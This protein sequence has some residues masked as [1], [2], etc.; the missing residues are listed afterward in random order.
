MTVRIK[1]SLVVS[2]VVAIAAPALPSIASAACTWEWLCNGGGACRQTP[3]CDA[4]DEVPPAKPEMAPP[5]PPP[6]AMRPQA[7]TSHRGG[8]VACEQ[9]MRQT[10]AGNWK[11]EEACYCGDDTKVPDPS[12]PMSNIA[13]CQ[14]ASRTAGYIAR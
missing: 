6:L 14:S 2:L 13:R 10:A 5:V 12:Q 3:V 11:W 9:V 7:A 1:P 8:D 4:L